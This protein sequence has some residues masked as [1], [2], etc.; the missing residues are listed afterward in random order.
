M[1][2]SLSKTKL[3]FYTSYYDKID[4][5][6]ALHACISFGDFQTFLR[7]TGETKSRVKVAFAIFNAISPFAI[8]FVVVCLGVVCWVIF[9]LFVD[10]LSS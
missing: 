7:L 2:S 9:C 8:F 10:L 6:C 1:L 4:L 3:D 5:H